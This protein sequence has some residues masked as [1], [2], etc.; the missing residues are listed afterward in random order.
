MRLLTISSCTATS[1]DAIFA[2][3]ADAAERH[4]LAL[5]PVAAASHSET[6]FQLRC[7]LVCCKFGRSY[8]NLRPPRNCVIWSGRANQVK[9]V[10]FAEML[11]KYPWSRLWRRPARPTMVGPRGKILGIWTLKTLIF[12]TFSP[13]P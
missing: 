3:I 8:G 4:H 7:V 5:F 11:T 10:N 13:T 1:N 12:L 6:L 2:Y 9:M